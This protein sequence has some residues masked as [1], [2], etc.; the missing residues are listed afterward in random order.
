MLTPNCFKASC[1]ATTSSEKGKLTISDRPFAR[2]ETISARC[3]YDLDVMISSSPSSGVGIKTSVFIT[4][5]SQ[6]FQYL[7]CIQIVTHLSF[8]FY[9]KRYGVHIR[10]HHQCEFLITDID[11]GLVK[12]H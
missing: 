6:G 5:Q 3:A 12:Q 4:S 11:A 9:L 8:V 1:V 10:S 2:L 7:L